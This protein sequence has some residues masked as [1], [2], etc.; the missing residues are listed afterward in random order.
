MLLAGVLFLLVSGA[1]A[2][3]PETQN[4]EEPI[5][6]S[7]EVSRK[8]KVFVYFPP[9]EP[10]DKRAREVEGEV[11]LDVVACSDGKV[12]VLEVV[13]GLPYGLTEVSI[14][15]ALKVKF[16]PAERDGQKVS[17]RIRVH[18]DFDR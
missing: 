8:A 2:Q 18:Y 17:Q 5:Y 14:D 11:V 16:R 9:A 6:S 1:Q 10:A 7:K 3:E 15:A 4:C 12:K 13:K